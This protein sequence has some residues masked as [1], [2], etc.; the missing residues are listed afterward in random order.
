M[1]KPKIIIAALILALSLSGAYLI[2]SKKEKGSVLPVAIEENNP[3]AMIKPQTTDPNAAIN[4]TEI[5]TA[6][7]GEDIITKN[8]GGGLITSSGDKFIAAPEPEQMANDLIAEAQKNFDPE[9]LRPK[10]EE[11]DLKI[12]ADNT[13]EGFIGY[14]NSLNQMVSA[15]AEKIPA[16][17]VDPEKI[18]VNDF[19]VTALVYGD[20]IQNLYSLSAP[21]Q[22]TDI[23]KKQ[24]ELTV[25]KKNILEKAANAEQDPLTAIISIDSLLIIDQEFVKLKEDMQAWV[26]NHNL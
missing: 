2:I 23:H 10:I 13:K 24:I 11:K 7:I 17:F 25:F 5:I 19:K 8:T 26:K 6:K 16:G 14:F 21:S 3:V 1:S 20:F 15:A 9:T 18:S 22:L 4:L 12:T